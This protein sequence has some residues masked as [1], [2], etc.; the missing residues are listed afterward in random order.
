MYI[1]DL[2]IR[3]GFLRLSGMLRTGLLR[4]SGMLRTGLLRTGKLRSARLTSRQFASLRYS[5][6]I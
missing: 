3:S 4:L 2:H 1:P 5:L 6:E